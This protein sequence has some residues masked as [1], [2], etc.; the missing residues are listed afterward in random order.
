MSFLQVL[1][2]PRGIEGNGDR[3]EIA[4]GLEQPVKI[5]HCWQSLRTSFPVT[6]IIVAPRLLLFPCSAAK[7]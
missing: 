6:A 2:C 3:A 1:D 5:P 4:I 7:R